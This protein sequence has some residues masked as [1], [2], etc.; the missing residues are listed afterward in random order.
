M[1]TTK[2]EIEVAYKIGQE[3][4]K[5]NR[6]CSIIQQCIANEKLGNAWDK[7]NRDAKIDEY[8]FVEL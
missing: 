1:K 3:D 7:G 4:F 5:A 2:Q 8:K 6:P